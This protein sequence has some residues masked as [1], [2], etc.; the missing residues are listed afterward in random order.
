MP[1]GAGQNIWGSAHLRA[2]RD[3][4]IPISK[5]AKRSA[6]IPISKLVAL[7]SPAVS[8]P[9]VA[10][11]CLGRANARGHPPPIGRA[12]SS[13]IGAIGGYS[14][15]MGCAPLGESRDTP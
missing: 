7:D 9:K 10:L 13:W 3:T 15:T 8:A 6:P 11:K 5:P 12:R 4:P 1:T 14:T 2:E